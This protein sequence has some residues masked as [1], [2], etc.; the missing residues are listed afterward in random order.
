MVLAALYCPHNETELKQNSFETVSKQFWN[1]FETVLKQFRNSFETV[2][3]QFRFI[4]R[5]VS[6][7]ED[8]VVV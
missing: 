7:D 2:W 4:V 6:H 3:F 8:A 5:T 1:S